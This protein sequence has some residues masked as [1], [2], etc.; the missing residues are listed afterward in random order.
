M[1]E[2]YTPIPSYAKR[3]SYLNIRIW[4]ITFSLSYVMGDTRFFS[5]L[6]YVRPWRD[7][8]RTESAD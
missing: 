7:E 4:M 1:M 6:I 5:E 8:V 3:H 2:S